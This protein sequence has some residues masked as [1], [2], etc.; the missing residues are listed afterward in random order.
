[1]RDIRD[2]DVLILPGWRNSEPGHWQSEWQSLFPNMSRVEQEDWNSPVYSEWA[3]NL[4]IA[5]HG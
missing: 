5:V 4:S 2:F 1:V 3:K